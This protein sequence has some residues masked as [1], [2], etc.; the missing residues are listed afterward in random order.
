MAAG[1][2]REQATWFLQIQSKIKLGF[3]IDDD[4]HHVYNLWTSHKQNLKEKLKS[5]QGEIY[6]VLSK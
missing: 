4:P 2:N 5:L 1:D 6:S 3:S